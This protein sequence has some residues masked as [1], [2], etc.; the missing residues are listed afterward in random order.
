[1]SNLLLRLN[2]QWMRDDWIGKG[3]VAVQRG[4][5]I[6]KSLEFVAARTLTS[7]SYIALGAVQ[8]QDRCE[9]TR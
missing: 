6:W 5:T 8:V 4:S 2:G 3:F 1:M 9:V 7:T